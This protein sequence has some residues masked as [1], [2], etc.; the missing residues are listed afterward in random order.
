MD[1]PFD[2]DE[3]YIGKNVIYCCFGTGNREYLNALLVEEIKK[4]FRPEYLLFTSDG[5]HD[6]IE[7]NEIKKLLDENLDDRNKILALLDEA[8]KNGSGDDC[9]VVIAR[10]TD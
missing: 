9:T 7:A 8:E 10:I 1:R 3:E 2:K 6:Y 5:I 4:D